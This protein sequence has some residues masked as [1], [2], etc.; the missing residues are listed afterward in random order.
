[1]PGRGGAVCSGASR[2]SLMQIIQDRILQKDWLRDHGFPVGRYRAVESEAE[3]QEAALALGGR[4]F[5]K[6][7]RG[8]YDGRGQAKIGFAD[9]SARLLKRYTMRGWLWASG[10]ASPSRR[11]ISRRRSR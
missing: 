1:M 9:G 8:G 10:R 6:T 5:V 7:A 3:L 11:S 2:P 4:C